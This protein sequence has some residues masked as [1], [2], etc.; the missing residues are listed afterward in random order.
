MVKRQ[1]QL[2]RSGIHVSAED[3][4]RLAAKIMYEALQQIAHSDGF[5]D[6]EKRLANIARKALRDL[7]KL[8]MG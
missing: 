3:R 6:G 1:E 7:D 5:F 8:S 4:A 2:E